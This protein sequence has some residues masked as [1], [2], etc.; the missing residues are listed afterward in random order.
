MS[1]LNVVVLDNDVVDFID[2]DDDNI[3]LDGDK[4]CGAIDDDDDDNNISVVFT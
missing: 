2:S 1:L 4:I 3:E